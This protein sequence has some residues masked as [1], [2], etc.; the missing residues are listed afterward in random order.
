MIESNFVGDDRTVNTINGKFIMPM[1]TPI[2]I[3]VITAK[4]IFENI[5]FIDNCTNSKTKLKRSFI[6]FVYCCSAA[7]C[8]LRA[9]RRALSSSVS[10]RKGMASPLTSQEMPKRVRRIISK[11]M[12]R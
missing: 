6:V 8:C 12:V 7:S 1:I 9:A 4:P 5:H 10:L 2:Q 3:R 11:T